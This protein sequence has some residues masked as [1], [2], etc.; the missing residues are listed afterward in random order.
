MGRY[1][2]VTWTEGTSS[3]DENMIPIDRNQTLVF[4]ESEG[5]DFLIPADEEDF[6]G[7]HFS[8]TMANDGECLRIHDLGTNAGT[9]V[10]EEK[11]QSG[12]TYVYNISVIRIGELRIWFDVLYDTEEFTAMLASRASDEELVLRLLTRVRTQDFPSCLDVLCEKRPQAAREWMIRIVERASSIL[13]EGNAITRADIINKTDLAIQ[14]AA[15]RTP[16]PIKSE[17]ALARDIG[18]DDLS[19]LGSD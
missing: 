17:R 19:T 4:G 2:N 1:L 16:T 15:D 9:F 6:K 3:A 11:V 10:D 8:I 13:H 12:G 7:R 5:D 18:D 14:K